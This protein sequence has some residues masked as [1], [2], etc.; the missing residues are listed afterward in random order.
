MLNKM[1]KEN[2]IN[3]LVNDYTQSKYEERYLKEKISEILEFMLPR[4][5][6]VT[7][8]KN[9]K[10]L[11]NLWKAVKENNEIK[12]S[13]KELVKKI[14]LPIIIYVVSKFKNNKY[15]GTKIIEEAL[16]SRS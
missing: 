7:K 8:N 1:S 4:I 3:E 5:G 14:K 9:E 12:S 15:F 6:I 13:F 16:K 2:L 10:D 11:V